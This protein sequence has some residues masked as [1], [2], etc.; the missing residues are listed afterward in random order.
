[1]NKHRPPRFRL[2]DETQD[3]LN[4]M[5]RI[6][7]K[8]ANYIINELILNAPMS[9]EETSNADTVQVRMDQ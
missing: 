6:T 8:P 2:R 1:M 5:V 3:K 7:G 9:G 4:E